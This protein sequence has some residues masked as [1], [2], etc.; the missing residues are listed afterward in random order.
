[1]ELVE[2]IISE[3]TFT[4]LVPRWVGAVLC[5]VGVL[6]LLSGFLSKKDPTLREG[7]GV[8]LALC[9]ALALFLS[10][11]NTTP[12]DPPVAVVSVPTSTTTTMKITNKG[13]V[14][15]C[16]MSGG[17]AT[18]KDV[19]NGATIAS[20]DSTGRVLSEKTLIDGRL[21]D[22]PSTLTPRQGR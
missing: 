15:F 20:Y 18:C 7:V 17:I 6:L 4:P 5:G 19:S 8:I 2:Y 13:G 16:E 11:V 14:S 1:M 21:Y 22:P 10:G 9:G 12:S 3:Q